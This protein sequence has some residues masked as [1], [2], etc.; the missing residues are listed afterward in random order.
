[1]GKG[2]GIVFQENFVL[3]DS[4]MNFLLIYNG[5]CLI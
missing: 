4:R 1:M 2:K 5:K 3:E